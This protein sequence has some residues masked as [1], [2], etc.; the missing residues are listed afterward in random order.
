MPRRTPKAHDDRGV[1]TTKEEKKGRW[2]FGTLYDITDSHRSSE[3]IDKTMMTGYVGQVERCPE[4]G[5]LH[6]QFVVRFSQ[7]RCFD[8]TRDLLGCHVEPVVSPKHAWAY[9][10]KEK[11]RV[12]GPWIYG[13]L[14]KRTKADERAVLLDAARTGARISTV[15]DTL[16]LSIYSIPT[17]ARALELLREPFLERPK[18]YYHYGP[19]GAGKTETVYMRHG[20]A[21]VFKYSSEG[22]VHCLIPYNGKP[23]LCIEEFDKWPYYPGSYILPLCDK[24]EKPVRW[25]GGSAALTGGHVYFTANIPPWEL[26]MSGETKLGFLRRLSQ[27]GEVIKFDADHTQT[28][29]TL[30][31]EP[32]YGPI[33]APPTP[34]ATGGGTGSLCCDA[35][36][37]SNS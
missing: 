32:P 6:L 29:I 23:V 25:V 21:S 1:S 17:I 24:G 9:C 12:E 28:R 20:L 4:S 31:S 2:W 14:D 5:R 18:I 7:D 16:D 30:S 36:S 37:H 26:N 22:N 19:S 15:M 13:V 35:Y 3:W 33:D 34:Y 8:W 27:Y 10:Q 11:T